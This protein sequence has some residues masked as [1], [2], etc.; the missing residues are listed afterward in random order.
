M[1]SAP[2][3]TSDQWQAKVSDLDIASAIHAGRGKMPKFDLLPDVVVRGLVLR[4][5][6]MRNR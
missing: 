1:V 4:I 2:D 5:R 3:L 6:S